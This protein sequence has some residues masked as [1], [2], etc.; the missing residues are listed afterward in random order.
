MKRLLA[1]LGILAML[2]PVAVYAVPAIVQPGAYIGIAVGHT[3]LDDEVSSVAFT[4]EDIDD[5]SYSIYGGYRF[6]PFF[7]VEAAYTDIGKVEYDWGATHHEFD[8]DTFSAAAI[9]HLPLAKNFELFGKLGAHR[10][11]VDASGSGSEHD[12]DLFY[13]A[14][15]TYRAGDY[16][17]R[18]GYD[19]YDMSEDTIDYDL[20]V[21]YLGI[22]YHY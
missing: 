8:I 1:S 5:T 7:G 4:N 16:S 22:Q 18:A 11:A 3:N 20:N 21:Y 2:M 14:G 9:A 17:F 12:V 6:N 15:V 19:Q 10:W 13:G